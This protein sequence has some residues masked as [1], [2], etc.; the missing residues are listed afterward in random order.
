M[1]SGASFTASTTTSTSAVAAPPLPSDTV[2]VNRSVPC[3][4]ASGA[5]STSPPGT[6]RTAPRPGPRHRLDPERVALHV[7]VVRQ[8][9]DQ[10][11]L[12]PRPSPPRRPWPPARRSPARPRPRPRRSPCRPLPS[13]TV[14][15]N[16]SVPCQSASGAYSTSPPAAIRTVP[17][18]GPVTDSTLSASALDV[19]VVR[20]N[21]DHHRLVLGRPRHVGRGL[22]RARSR[23]P[24]STVTRAR[25]SAPCGSRALTVNS[26]RFGSVS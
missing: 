18:P 10:D 21:V 22:R 4:S 17:R 14:Y 7:G 16:R 25:A 9:V 8:H 1:A 12:V 3:Q 19:R 24:T 26:Y 2:Y 5:Y 15:V 20:Q 23:P 11:R 13:V 6:I